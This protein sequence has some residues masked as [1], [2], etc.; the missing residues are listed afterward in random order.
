MNFGRLCNKENW[1][2]WGSPSHFNEGTRIK[3][4]VVHDSMFF[5]TLRML[6]IENKIVRAHRQFTP[7]KLAIMHVPEQ[8]K[9]IFDL[10]IV[11]VP[12]HYPG[13]VGHWSLILWSFGTNCF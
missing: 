11:L 2:R 3:S 12:V 5:D 9:T 8:I 13:V 10:D 6:R 1:K 7:S 4:L